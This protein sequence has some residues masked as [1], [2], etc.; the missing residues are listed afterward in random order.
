M[1][2]IKRNEI[3]ISEKETCYNFKFFIDKTLPFKIYFTGE[4]HCDKDFYFKRNSHSCYSFEYIVSGSGV[5]NINDKTYYPKTG[6]I[7]FLSKNSTHEYYC[8]K[9]E[10]WH[11]IFI[12]FDGPIAEGLI[13]KYLPKDEYL[14]KNTGLYDVFKE[15]LNISRDISFDYN[16]KNDSV[17]SLLLKI[18]LKINR[19]YAIKPIFSLAE[20]IKYLLDIN[21]QSK[22]SINDLAKELS[23]SSNHIIKV[24]RAEYGETPYQYISKKRISL[25]KEYLVST[26]MSVQKIA[27][28]L[29]YADAQYFSNCFTK[30]VGVT[31]KRFRRQNWKSK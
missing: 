11:K 20:K 1:A 18:F 21:I 19:T 6:D 29:N 2:K 13:D 10:P 24:F 17:L 12:S 5:L 26:S 15:T 22:Y 16:Q 7:F 14:F 23:Y 27:D 4:S 28:T 31:P 25:A 9:D 3:I 8:T 30:A